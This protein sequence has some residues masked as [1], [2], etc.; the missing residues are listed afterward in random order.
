MFTYLFLRER[1]RGIEIDGQRESQTD[2]TVSTEP[3]VGL[4]LTN[5]ETMA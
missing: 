1:E 5:Y 2:S 3:D 4:Q